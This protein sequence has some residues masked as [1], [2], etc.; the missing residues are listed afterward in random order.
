MF[1]AQEIKKGIYWVGAVD[2]NVRSF[3]GHTYTTQRGTTYNAYL[4]VDEKVAVVDAVY[5]PFADELKARIASI[6]PLERVDY[7]IVNHIEVDHSG[8]LPALRAACP[9]ARLYGTAKCKEGLQ[10]M[11]HADWNVQTVKSGDILSLGK[12]TLRFIEAPMIHWPD[13]MFTYCPQEELLLSND[14]FG[15]HLASSGRFDD[16]VPDCALREEAAKYYANILWPLGGLIEKKIK[17][18][19]DLKIPISMIAP[20]HGVIWRRDPGSIIEAYL[21][22]ARNSC[23]AQVVIAYETMWGS[24]ARMARAIAEGVSSCGVPVRLFDIAESDRTAV[25]T[26]MLE[27]RG[28]LFG[29]STHDNAM[30][31][32]MAGFMDFVKGLKPRGRLTAAFGSYG[33]AGGAVAELEAQLKAAGLTVSQPAVT[34]QSVPDEGMLT[35]CFAWGQEF[36]RAVAKG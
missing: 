22:W 26:A 19:V 32:T 33:W 17:E 23:A 36:A 18:I 34:V 28:F 27:A 35:Q 4:I 24:T 1:K 20:S 31:P 25:V 14:A 6:V 10:R 29:S 15:Q 11:Y 30:L 16:E 8:A 5:G 3:H 13:S 9:Q 7:V 21:R 2:W 12:R